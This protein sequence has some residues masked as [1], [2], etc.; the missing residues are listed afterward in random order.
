MQNKGQHAR[1]LGMQLRIREAH[2]QGLTQAE[3]ADEFFVT[4]G[5]ISYHARRMGLKFE[6]GYPAQRRARRGSQAAAY[7]ALEKAVLDLL[8]RVE[9]LEK[10]L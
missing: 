9:R 1:I 2:A 4:R 5:A 6:V 7:A 8:E 10:R 3:I